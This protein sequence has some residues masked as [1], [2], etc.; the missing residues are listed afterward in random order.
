MAINDNSNTET[1]AELLTRVIHHPD[2][3]G[4]LEVAIREVFSSTISNELTDT[5]QFIQL[6]LEARE[7]EEKE[8]PATHIEESL[9]LC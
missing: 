3:P 6:A 7:R 1:L 9:L 5:R 8:E 4:E 2:L